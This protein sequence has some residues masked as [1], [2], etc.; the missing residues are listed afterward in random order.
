[1][2]V[3]ALADYENRVTFYISDLAQS[4]PSQ[5]RIEV[6]KAVQTLIGRDL[7]RVVEKRRGREGAYVLNPSLLYRGKV[8]QRRASEKYWTQ[9][10]L[11]ATVAQDSERMSD[12]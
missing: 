1:M 8:G 6:S 12:S 5:H 3:I 10:G 7:L 4:F 11:A 2:K 9:L